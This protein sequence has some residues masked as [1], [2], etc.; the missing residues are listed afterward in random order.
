MIVIES[1][2]A[3][4]IHSSGCLMQ[5]Y[6]KPILASQLLAEATTTKKQ[7]QEQHASFTPALERDIAVVALVVS[8]GCGDVCGGCIADDLIG[9]RERGGLKENHRCQAEER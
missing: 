5:G 9:G 7:K 8:F 3:R 4:F 6:E 1:R 2:K